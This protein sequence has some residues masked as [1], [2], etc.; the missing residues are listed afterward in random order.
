MKRTK[1]CVLVIV[2]DFCGFETMG[3]IAIFRQ[4]LGEYFYFFPITLSESKIKGILATPPK[5]IPPGIKG[6]IRPYYVKPMGFHKPL[7]RPAIS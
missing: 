7:I 3:F 5:A 6:L 1:A 2:G 4:H